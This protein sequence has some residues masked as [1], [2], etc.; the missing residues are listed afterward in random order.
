M[1][2]TPLPP[3]PR[4]RW[5]QRCAAVSAAAL[6]GPFAL[7][8]PGTASDEPPLTIAQIADMSP[9]QQDVSRDF[10][11]G[12]R[13]AWQDF[14]A[15]GGLRGRPVL[16]RVIEHHG[17]GAQLQSNWQ[18]L[19]ADPNCLALAGC[20][21]ER[22][23]SALVTLQQAER[24]STLAQIAPWLHSHS[25]TQGEDLLFGIFPDYRAQ[26]AHAL[27]NL[28]SMG[29]Q[30]LGVVYASAAL[31]TQM[32]A[33]V[34]QAARA[35]ALRTQAL[36][37]SSGRV[38][39]QQAMVLFVG[40]TPELHDFLRRLA[41]Q[42]GRQCFIVALADVNLQVLAQMGATPRNVSVIAT[43]AVPLVSAGL[44]IVR[45]YRERLAR[46]YDEPPSPQGLAGFISA[47]YTA[48]ALANVNGP[49]TR[50]SLLASLRQRQGLDLGGFGIAFQGRQPV[51]SSVTQSMLSSNGR[52]VG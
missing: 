48:Q 5:L 40:G 6:G 12:A 20:V 13:L 3:L 1:P 9:S 30:E 41:L 28:A 8:Q 34:Q 7:A 26:I 2:A 35:L 18:R 49:L 22:T 52:I 32:Q 42:P 46:L 15:R 25:T 10:V 11:T 37:E 31:R 50:A 4:R 44:P 38:Q 43:Q 23:A 24:G 14:N 19:Q 16:H 33:P 51:G 21:G 47:R 36:P 45:A 29:V 39:P 17:D 27:K